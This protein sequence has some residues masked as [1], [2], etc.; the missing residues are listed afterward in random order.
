MRIGEFLACC[1]ALT[2]RQV[3]EILHLQRGLRRRQGPKALFGR[4][5]LDRGCIEEADLGQWI[6]A[7]ALIEAVARG[8][9]AWPTSIDRVPA[10]ATEL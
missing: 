6:E 4:V 8:R 2:P 10:P 7:K 3:D 5:A 9:V 1:G